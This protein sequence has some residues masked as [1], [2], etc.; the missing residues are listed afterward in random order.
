M[1]TLVF[2]EQQYYAAG[3]SVSTDEPFLIFLAPLQCSEQGLAIL[4]RVRRTEA[5]AMYDLPA[6][7]VFW[8]LPRYRGLAS[9]SVLGWF[10]FIWVFCLLAARRKDWDRAILA[11]PHPI[12]IACGIA[13]LLLKKPFV[14]VV[15]ENLK[16]RLSHRYGGLLRAAA[17]GLAA[18]L[19]SLFFWLGRRSNVMAVGDEMVRVYEEHAVH[20]ENLAI[21][22]VT[23]RDL[24]CLRPKQPRRLGVDFRLLTVA[25]LDPDKGL[26]NLIDAIHL[27]RETGE[28]VVLTVVG[29]GPQ[30][31]DIER[32]VRQHGM[33]EAVTLAG[34]VKHGPD[35]WAFYRDADSFILPSLSGEGLP[36]VIIE[37]MAVGLPIIATTVGGIP[38]IVRD[39]QNGLLVRAGSPEQLAAAIRSLLL[40]RTLYER[41]SR[42]AL[43]GARAYTQERQLD[44]LRGH[45]LAS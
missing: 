34:Y 39:H 15:R 29:Q 4:G 35:L 28:R 31:A 13:C 19:Q 41:L 8:P 12:A 38:G 42:N 1:K 10:Y 43:E 3:N 45:L 30:R 14:L 33:D 9:L 2:V 20:A 26:L 32:R 23:D 44:I 21:S 5:A 11:G 7:S 6:G 17:V 36:Q 18:V 22:L 37:A 40:D 27:V 16:D 24:G 25:R